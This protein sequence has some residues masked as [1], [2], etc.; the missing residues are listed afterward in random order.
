L[1]ARDTSYDLNKTVSSSTNDV[2]LYAAK[3]NSREDVSLEGGVKAV[4]TAVNSGS[5]NL[6]KLD[7]F[8]SLKITVNDVTVGTFV[9]SS[10]GLTVDFDS[11]F[12]IRAGISTIKI[13]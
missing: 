9:P 2:V 7:A 13:T 10:T 4:F 11:T 3:I 6:G 1:I 8:S 12:T 5:T